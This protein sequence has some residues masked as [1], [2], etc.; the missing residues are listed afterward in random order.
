MSFK[1]MFRTQSSLHQTSYCT[2]TRLNFTTPVC[3]THAR[4]VMS[5]NGHQFS[6]D[7]STKGSKAGNKL[8]PETVCKCE[9]GYFKTHLYEEVF[10]YSRVDDSLVRYYKD[11]DN[12]NHFWRETAKILGGDKQTAKTAKEHQGLVHQDEEKCQV[13]E[14]RSRPAQ[15]SSSHTSGTAALFK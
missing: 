2:L 12:N 13:W 3:Q 15:V 5:F 1:L 9:T 8:I 6:F 4:L 14:Q 7:G 11:R 10:K